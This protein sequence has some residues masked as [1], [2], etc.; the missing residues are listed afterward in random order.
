MST[1]AKLHQM[2]TNEL[3][4][5]R[6]VMQHEADAIGDVAARL[7]SNSLQ[8]IELFD[9]SDGRIVFSGMG[10]MSYIARKAAATFCSTGSPAI[11]LHPAEAVHGDLGVVGPN[12]VFVALSYSGQTT[13]VLNLLPYMKRFGVPIVA[14]TGNPAGELGRRSDHV[15][16]IQVDSETAGDEIAPASSTT[17]ALCVCDALAIALARKRGFTN[18]Q[19]AL[20]HPGGNLGRKL[21]LTAQQIMHAD[22]AIPVA[23]PALALREAIVEVSQK[24]LGCVVVVQADAIVG[25]LTDGDIRRALQ[26]SDNPLSDPIQQYMTQAPVSIDENALAADALRLMQQRSITVLPVVCA[27]KKL[28]GI[29]HLHDLLKVGLA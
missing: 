10:K 24:R 27:E 16:D 15:I 1:K 5:L 21:L 28:A 14:I 20:F 25:I 3:A 26:K 12:D 22:T 17:V 29:I 19:F 8:A 11:F 4:V 7:D 18:E 9:N 23:A 13:E 6:E 2:Q